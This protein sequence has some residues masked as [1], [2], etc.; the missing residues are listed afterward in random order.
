MVDAVTPPPSA[1]T[2]FVV[3]LLF[4]PTA[5]FCWLIGLLIFATA[6]KLLVL[7]EPTPELEPAAGVGC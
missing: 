5:V 7:L 2:G 3:G 1:P 6:A 4:I